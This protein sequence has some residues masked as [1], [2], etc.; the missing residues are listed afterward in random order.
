MGYCISQEETNFF[1]SAK[2]KDAA[3]ASVK[4]LNPAD[5]ADPE[6]PDHPFSWVNTATYKA[7]QTLEE[8]LEEWRWLPSVDAEGNIVNVQFTGEKYGDEKVIFSAIAPYVKS[9][10]SIAMCGEDGDKWRWRFEDGKLR[11]EAGKNKKL[12]EFSQGGKD[13]RVVNV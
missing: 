5:Y 11:L 6:F 13:A 1:I 12:W 8:A 9:G 7:A 10:S 3:L 4:S 2:D